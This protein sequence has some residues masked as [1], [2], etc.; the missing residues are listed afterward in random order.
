MFGFFYNFFFDT[1]SF[2]FTSE[3]WPS[4]LRR[5]DIAI[6]MVTF[7]DFNIAYNLP[8][9]DT[10]AFIGWRYYFVFIVATSL[11]MGGALFLSSRD[12]RIYVRGNQHE[13]WGDSRGQV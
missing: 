12:K 10:L 9:S 2:V 13:I 4:H 5:K 6:S 1:R 11:N 7:D 8:A 3:I